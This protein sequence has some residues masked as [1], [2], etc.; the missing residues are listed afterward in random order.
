MWRARGFWTSAPVGCSGR[1][2]CPRCGGN[3]GLWRAALRARTSRRLSH[4]RDR[5]ARPARRGDVRARCHLCAR[6]WRAGHEGHLARR[7]RAH[8]HRRERGMLG[9]LRIVLGGLC[10]QLGHP[11]G[12]YR[13]GGL[14][15]AGAGKPGQPLHR[16][17]E[18]ERGVPSSAAARVPTTSWQ[19][20]AAP[21]SKTCS[22]KSSAF[23]TSTG[24]ASALWCRAVPFKNDAVLR[25]FEQYLGRSVTRAPHPGLMGAIGVA[26]LAAEHAHGE[27][28][29][30]GGEF[31]ASSFIGLDAWRALLTRSSRV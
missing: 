25:A 28:E 2:P 24:W 5:G 22:P 9:R 12:R 14:P 1:D 27:E 11:G 3:H 30:A 4:G 10:G 19:G 23:P 29:R 17:Y 18:L 20:S 21:S 26:L 7:R 13:S 31:G 6:H 8:R 16:V 15:L